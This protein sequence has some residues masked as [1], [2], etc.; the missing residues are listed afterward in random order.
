MGVWENKGAVPHLICFLSLSF[1]FVGLLQN[2]NKWASSWTINPP[3][4]HIHQRKI[5]TFLLYSYSSTFFKEGTLKF[6][7]STGNSQL[8][9]TA[10]PS[11]KTTVM[12]SVGIL[13]V[14]FVWFC[15]EKEKET[16]RLGKSWV[17][18]LNTLLSLVYTN[19]FLTNVWHIYWY[20]NCFRFQYLL[21]WSL[22]VFSPVHSLTFSQMAL[23]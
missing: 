14:G 9:V 18:D 6:W 7:L 16:K 4:A 3:R 21:A 23:A 15:V 2:W 5:N 12:P 11:Y 13:C 22:I 20:L 8:R 1:F 10:G 17:R 19:C